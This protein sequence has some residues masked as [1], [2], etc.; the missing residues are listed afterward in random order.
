MSLSQPR[1]FFGIHSVSFYNRQTWAFYGI[2]KVL[3]DSS[4]SLSAEAVELT[5]GS[6]KF[7][8][9]VEDG[10]ISAE[11]SLKTGQFEDFM[12]ELFFGQAPTTDID[13][14]TTGTVSTPIERVGTSVIDGTNGISTIVATSGDEADLK[15]G[16]YVLKATGAGTADLFI[17]SDVDFG[18]GTDQTYVN[19]LLKIES[20]N[21]ASAT[22]VSAI[23]GLTF[24]KVGT[25]AFVVGDVATFYVM[26]VSNK[27]SVVKV[28]AASAQTMPEFGALIMGAKR[29]NGEM[30]EVDLFRC[31]ASGMPLP[32]AQN[33]FAETELKAKAFYDADRDGVF[34]VHH[35]TPKTF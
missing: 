14:S 22:H 4:L 6:Q 31:K 5:G 15:F 23:T 25:P 10:A 17:G 26:P 8:Y 29:S 28:G 20:I 33:A 13:G 7:P 18:R 24:T 19:D 12:F 34:E 16:S 35:V 27:T 30:V 3:K 2:L 9:A 32:F 1:S 11:M 21:V